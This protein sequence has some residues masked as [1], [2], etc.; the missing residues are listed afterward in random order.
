MAEIEPELEPEEDDVILWKDSESGQS[1][2]FGQELVDK[3]R[4]D[5]LGLLDEFADVLRDKPGRTTLTGH[6]IETGTATPTHQHPYRLPHA[7]KD[8]VQQ[9]LKE[10]LADGIVEPSMSEWAAPIVLVKKKDGLFRFCVD[11]RKLNSVSRVD[12][13]PMPRMDELIDNLG[14]AQFVTTLDLTR[15]Y[16]Q[17]PMSEESRAKTAFTTG[18]GL[19]QFRV[20]PF[21]LQG[22]PATFQR[23]MDQLLMGL[24]GYTAAYLDDLVIFSESWPDHLEHIQRVLQ[25]LREAGL[26]VKPKKCQF[27]MKECVYLGHVVGNGT[28]KPEHGKLEAVQNFPIPET[29]SQV[30][31]FLGLT[32]YYR[33]FIPGYSSIAAPLTDLTKKYAPTKVAWS[34]ACATAFRKLQELLC[35]SPVLRSPDFTRSFILQTDASD[36]GIGAVLS[37]E[38]SEGEEH[39]VAYFSRKLLP[40][41]ER[42]STVEKECLAIKLGIQAFRVYLMGKPFVI[43]TDHRSLVWL[44]RLK[45]NNA[46][47]TRWSL[48]LQPYQ[49]IVQHRSGRA[50]GNADALSR[51][52][53]ARPTVMS[54]EKG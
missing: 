44:D 43:Q 52:D 24:E 8:V 22:A 7:Y 41:E 14:Q 33:R 17:V 2:V 25:R 16:W 30:R 49:F 29:K 50:N 36:R 46:R 12:A 21:G 6:T 47:L 19:Y 3:Q 32:G 31:A 39:P 34:E 15:G 40:R 1:P 37:Q 38:D 9:E 35:S 5:L 18:F 53:P 23:M 13:Y 11:Y 10:M 54:L 26:T 42:Y 45:E 4:R 20:M 27:G 28:V 51:V 48:A